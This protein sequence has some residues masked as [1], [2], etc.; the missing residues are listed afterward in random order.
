MTGIPPLV[1]GASKGAWRR[2]AND[3]W[4]R[5][6]LAGLSPQV[7]GHLAAWEPARS[8]ETILFYLPMPGEIDLSGFSD[9]V[10][11]ARLL[12]TRTPLDGPLTVHPLS[13]PL[14]RHR[15]GFMQPVADAP[16][17]D[18]ESIDVALIPGRVFDRRGGRLGRGAAYYDRLL[19]GLKPGALLV[20]VCP[21]VLIADRLPTD[22]HDV[23]MTHLA[24]ELGV[25]A[26][27]RGAR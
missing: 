4:A 13:V 9:G 27:D 8:A 11:T 3:T 5:I 21:S 17:A 25:E 14:E 22:E 24:T 2:W 23:R 26:V 1:P 7:V 19:P 10:V 15:Y 16:H 18:P 6:D 12:V 20:G